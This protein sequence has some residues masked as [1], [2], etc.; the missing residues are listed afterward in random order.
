M[1]KAHAKRGWTPALMIKGRRNML[2]EL[3]KDQIEELLSSQ[4]L[5]R[6]GCY[7][8]GR[9]YIMLVNYVYDGEAIYA[10]SVEGLKL[11][12]MRCNPHVCFEV[13]SVVNYCNWQSAIVW[14]T[15]EELRGEDAAYAVSL[16]AQR[17]IGAIASG[18]LL[19][20]IEARTSLEE[21]R[22]SEPIIV[23]R[24]FLKEKSGRFEKV[25]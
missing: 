3:R 25:E 11:Q 24:I 18:Q 8:E 2:G 19:H 16:L 7:A 1:G 13:D 20:E 6:L 10:R 12:L 17:L 15:F 9:P 14:G 21:G 22:P 4:T 5:G 23:Y